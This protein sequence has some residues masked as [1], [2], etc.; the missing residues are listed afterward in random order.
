[1]IDALAKHAIPALGPD[2][3]SL[4]RYRDFVVERS[5]EALRIILERRR[6]AGRAMDYSGDLPSATTVWRVAKRH[7]LTLRE[8]WRRAVGT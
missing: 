2:P 4:A 5:R 1:M 3:V 6:E 7:D 8:L